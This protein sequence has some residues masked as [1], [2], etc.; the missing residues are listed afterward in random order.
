MVG[1]ITP[2]IL[3][4]LLKPHGFTVTERCLTDW[5]RKGDLPPLTRRSRGYRAGVLRYWAEKDILQ[6]ALAICRR[7]RGL[8]KRRDG[9]IHSNWLAGVNIPASRAQ[10][11]W[12]RFLKKARFPLAIRQ[13][14]TTE[15][16]VT[17]ALN[18]S[19]VRDTLDEIFCIFLQPNYAIG[20]AL[21]IS[22]IGKLIQRIANKLAAPHPAPV[23]NEKELVRFLAGINAMF[24]PA[25]FRDVI[26]SATCA[27]LSY[28]RD[29]YL[30]WW[31]TYVP[32]LMPL[33]H[34]LGPLIV[35][36]LLPAKAEFACLAR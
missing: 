1:E 28:A 10:T 34:A 30:A 23:I 21:D 14:L 29:R 3:V 19:T 36:L 2:A 4:L 17:V 32:S 24:S 9:V 27:E 31:R 26:E 8:K 18:P 33:A 16:K 7:L 6:Q 22:F 11:A 15:L 5:R 35:P 20:V 25:G 12:V 13:K